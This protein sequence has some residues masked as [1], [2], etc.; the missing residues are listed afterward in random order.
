MWYCFASFADIAAS[1]FVLVSCSVAVMGIRATTAIIGCG[2]SGFVASYGL[3]RMLVK[4]TKMIFVQL[5]LLVLLMFLII[6]VL[7]LLLTR[8]VVIVLS[9]SISLLLL[10]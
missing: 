1:L 5:T 2:V 3:T 7:H 8:S 4:I 6:I 9:W 10:L